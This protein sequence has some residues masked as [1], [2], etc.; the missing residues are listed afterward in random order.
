MHFFGLSAVMSIALVAPVCLAQDVAT[1][2]FASPTQ[3]D[4]EASPTVTL[5]PSSTG[6]PCAAIASAVSNSE[7]S[8]VAVDAEIAYACLQSVPIN[9]QAANMTIDAVIRMVEF[10]STLSFLKNPPDGYANDP[11]DLIAGLNDIW[12][13]VLDGDYSKEYD[14]EGDIS[15][16]LDKA[17]DGHLGFE[18]YAWSGAF[19][20]RRSR[21]ITLG[22]ASTDGNTPKV[23]CIRDFNTSG[24]FTPSAVSQI[25][26][27]D[28]MTFMEDLSAKR[29]YHDA[30]ARWNSLSLMQAAESG[31]GFIGPP[32]YPGP[33]TT[34]TFENGTTSTFLNTAIVNDV[35]NWSGVSN[36]QQFYNA[37]VRVSS[38]SN[39]NR[40]RQI[41]QPLMPDRILPPKLRMQKTLALERNGT[42]P[43]GYPEP[44]L[45][46]SN[47]DVPFGGFFIDNHP[48]VPNLAVLV[49][50]TF[51]T[52]D[53]ADTQEW[54]MLLQNFLAE[55]K[56]RNTEKIII[57]VRDNGGGKIF[58]GYET[59]KQFFPEIVPFGGNRYRA[60][61]ASDILGNEI[62]QLPFSVTTSLAYSSSWNYRMYLDDQ[63]DDFADWDAMFGPVK[64]NGDQFTNLLR[65]NLSN[66]LLTSDPNFGLG[67]TITGYDDRSN[68]TES[69]FNASDIIIVSP[70]A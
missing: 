12:K 17:Y 62:S 11:V 51:S 10:Q 43:A 14:F 41:N 15:N 63:L 67:I 18:G 5:R 69:P 64:V 38:S 40:K 61:N 20:W 70:P 66:P 44:F 27:Q 1:S 30:D 58:L 23:Y 26:G 60:N 4:S 54:Q 56:T 8:T 13:K 25:N 59:F 50:Q 7:S 52:T 2:L 39:N 9:Q 57:D 24:S 33:N 34:L 16:L 19:T 37:M 42:V 32:D 68:F 21:A 49:I 47:P 36:G 6:E 22:L 45:E 48:S 28:V 29:L 35:N 3:T 31:G 53:T 65:Y 46:H 55:A